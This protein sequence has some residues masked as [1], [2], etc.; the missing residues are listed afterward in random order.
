MAWILTLATTAGPDQDPGTIETSRID[1]LL[2]AVLPCRGRPGDQ[3]VDALRSSQV[4][5]PALTL[6]GLI[7]VGTRHWHWC[8]ASTTGVTE[9]N[10]HLLDSASP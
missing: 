9:L 3:G 6:V 10:G 4:L 2:R 7:Q 8:D 1:R 5:A